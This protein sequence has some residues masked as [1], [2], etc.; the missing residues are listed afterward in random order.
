MFRKICKI[1]HLTLSRET[2]P[3]PGIERE[4]ALLPLEE[5]SITFA[6]RPNKGTLRKENYRPISPV[7]LDEKK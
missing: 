3:I 2:L 1:Y 6:F 5:A 7:N 4:K